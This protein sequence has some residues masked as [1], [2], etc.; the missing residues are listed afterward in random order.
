MTYGNFQHAVNGRQESSK[1]RVYLVFSL[2]AGLALIAVVFSSARKGDRPVLAHASVS[3]YDQVDQTISPGK[4]NTRKRYFSLASDSNVQG[5][6]GFPWGY[7]GD[8]GPAKWGSLHGAWQLCDK[9]PTQSPVNIVTSDIKADLDLPGLTWQIPSSSEGSGRA[10][11][12][13]D[14]HSICLSQLQGVHLD[15]VGFSRY[16]D[17]LPLSAIEHRNFSLV[18]MRVHTPSEH[19]V[20][21]HRSPLP[22]L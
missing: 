18:E 3:I 7:S 14:G 17:S 12:F 4:P 20:D 1:R 15:I 13:Y 5:A 11:V 19:T 16:L 8:I 6:G 10:R 2:V 9:G 21:G 22:P